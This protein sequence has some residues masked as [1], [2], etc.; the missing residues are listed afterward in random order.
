MPASQNKNIFDKELEQRIEDLKEIKKEK[1]SLGEKAETIKSA[2][3]KI[4]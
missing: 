4:F 1:E 2:F 3:F